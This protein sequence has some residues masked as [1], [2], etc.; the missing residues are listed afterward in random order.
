MKGKRGMADV[1]RTFMKP[2]SSGRLSK[3]I[4]QQ[5]Y[6]KWLTSLAVGNHLPPQRQPNYRNPSS[7]LSSPYTFNNHWELP[8]YK[9]LN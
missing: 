3:T 9:D 8:Y 4:T 6:L 7:S 5:T 1:G 2:S